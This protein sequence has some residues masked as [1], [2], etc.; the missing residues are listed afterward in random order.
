VVLGTIP[1]S[2]VFLDRPV[3][4]RTVEL[5]VKHIGRLL[6]FTLLSWYMTRRTILAYFQF[7]RLTRLRALGI[8]TGV[9]VVGA[10]VLALLIAV[11]AIMVARLG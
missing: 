8:L 2:I 11:V 9:I 4:E 5:L 7:Q 6:I 10:V 3:T 1:F